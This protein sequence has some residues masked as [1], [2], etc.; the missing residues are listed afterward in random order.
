MKKTNLLFILTFLAYGLTTAQTDPFASPNSGSVGP[1]PVDPFAAPT[2]ISGNPFEE[3]DPLSLID[4]EEDQNQSQAEYVDALPTEK[5]RAVVVIEGAKGRGT[6][7]VAKI[8]GILFIVTNVHVIKDNEKLVFMTMDGTNLSVGGVYAAKGYD[9]AILRIEE[10]D[11]QYFFEI[12]PDVFSSVSVGTEILIPGNSMG[13]GTVLQTKGEVVAVGPKLIEHDAPTFSG[14]SGSPIINKENWEVIG[15]DTLSTKRDLLQWFNQ[16]SKEHKESQIK[17]DVRLFGYRIDNVSEW[18]RI[19]FSELQRQHDDILEIQTEAL[20]VLSAVWGTDWHYQ[21]SDTVS[22]I[23]NRFI[24]KTSNS[25]L[26]VQDVEH[27]KKMARSALFNHL[28]SMQRKAERNRNQAYELMR[29]DYS[30]TIVF[31]DELIKYAGRYYESGSSA[32]PFE[33]R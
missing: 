17:N 15:V 7:F 33:T 2:G 31:C 23:I 4:A 5:K 13:D 21:R 30:N 1:Q 10:Q 14:N 11:H 18:E 32:D 9:V 12:T 16:H 28:K 29:E 6:G 27:Q 19:R 20:S 22:R 26:A 8:N 3:D 24:E 25:S